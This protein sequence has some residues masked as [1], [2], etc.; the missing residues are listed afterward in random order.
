MSIKSIV[1]SCG[2]ILKIQVLKLKGNNI[3][4]DR[5]VKLKKCYITAKNGE[6]AFGKYTTVMPNSTLE[7]SDKGKINLCGSNFI[8]RNCV[9]SAKNI[10]S[11]GEGTTIGPGTL[12]YDH[13]HDPKNK[14]Q[15]VSQPINIGKNVWIGGGCIIL[16]GVTIGDDAVVAA[17]TVVTDD[18]PSSIMRYN[19]IIPVAKNK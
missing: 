6:I 9:L 8:N 17:G 2:R 14:G 5:S 7:V 12:I 10:I 18:V 3:S 15:F 11:I 16:K 1:K 19:R 13:D 4:A